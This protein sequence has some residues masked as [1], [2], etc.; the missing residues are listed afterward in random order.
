[1][2]RSAFVDLTSTP[3]RSPEPVI[4]FEE[5][6]PTVGLSQG[7]SQASSQSDHALR[8]IKRRRLDDRSSAVSSSSRP[9]FQRHREVTSFTDNT[10]ESVDLTEVDDVTSLS[11]ILSKQCEDAIKAQVSSDANSGRSTLTAYKC[12]VCMDTAVDATTTICGKCSISY[13][14]I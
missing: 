12:P 10:I 2:D 8:G 14:L 6:M 7:N 13:L 5:G 4:L 9:S 3:P 1:M 11:K